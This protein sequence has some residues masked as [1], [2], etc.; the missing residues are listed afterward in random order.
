M[1]SKIKKEDIYMEQTAKSNYEYKINQ[2]NFKNNK[3]I[4]PSK[5]TV[6]VGANNCGK[7]QLLKDMLKYILGDSDDLVLLDNLNLN[8]PS[9][10]N[11]FKD[12][13]SMNFV[14]RNGQQQLQFLNATLDNLSDGIVGHNLKDLLEN[15]LKNNRDQFRKF[16]GSGIVTFLST[17]NRLNLVKRCETAKDFVRLGPSKVLEALFLAGTDVVNQIREQ[18]K[19]IF[20]LEI[21]FDD[22]EPGVLQ[23]RVGHDFSKISQNRMDQ[24]NQLSQFPILD[25]Q[26]DG[27]RSFVGI[28]TSIISLSRPVIFLD[29]PE[30]FLH[31]PQ[32]MKL[33]AIIAELIKDSHQIFISTHSADFLRGLLSTTKEAEIVHLSREGENNTNVRVLDN[34]MLNKI[35][36]D[37]LLSSS[38]VLEG[39][40]YKGVVATEADADAVFYQRLYQMIGSSDEIHFINAHNK[41]TLKKI[42]EPYKC[43]GIRCAL[44]ADADVIRN[45]HEFMD[46]IRLIANE[47]T[48]D[49]ILQERT[50]V[51]E[52]FKNKD[53]RTILY[54]LQSDLKMLVNQE[55]PTNIDVE[56]V[57]F[58]FRKMLKKLRDD[59]DE[60]GRFKQEGR[61]SLTIELQKTFDDL[62]IHCADLGL[63]IVPV[64]ELESW[65]LDYGIDRKSNKSKWISEALNRIYEIEFNN[66][67]EIWKF[68]N[69]LKKYF[70]Q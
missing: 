40:F 22:S 63:F 1:R 60:L 12:V 29:E 58:E 18:V 67:K 5:I 23:F 47:E 48:R 51:Y 42:I 37:P 7:T 52:S 26:G 17:D 8:Y 15:Y 2:I 66:E 4:K 55:L 70:I 36:A 20:D 35:I 53:K 25:N 13:C 30:A 56:S 59:S 49:T 33:G 68:M 9:S 61:A 19:N 43:L 28:L 50:Q 27:L 44:I 46:I 3:S 69:S 10:L 32:A 24:I 11:E 62:L 16:T 57:L 14:Q 6:F 38:R 31:P 65:L 41:Q 64:G 45:K 39:M 34:E 54:E 21:Y